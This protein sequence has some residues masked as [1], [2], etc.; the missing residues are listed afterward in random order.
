MTVS[1][2]HRSL[3]VTA[4]ILGLSLG[5]NLSAAERVAVVTKVKGTV[6]VRPA[7]SNPSFKQVKAGQVLSDRDFLR[8]GPSAFAVLIYLDDK[9]MVK[10]K[11][12]TNLEIQ[13]KRVGKGLEKNLEMTG[14]TVKAVVSKQR[15]GGF[16]ITSP[17]SVASVKG[18]SFWM[19][20]SLQTGDTV[21]NEEGVVQLTNLLSGSVL[22][23]LA[24]QTG[25]STPDGALSVA[26]TIAANVPVDEDEGDEE[27]Q[28]LRIRFTTPDGEEK[29]LI[30]KYH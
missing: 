8:T 12:N 11:G 9:S 2:H 26:A 20:S 15:R 27:V 30:I 14:G 7:T 23:L 16:T 17:T 10:L 18:T 6:E 28:E 19:V 1:P 21:F 29:V 13:G 3:I 4:L 25:T 24:D 5:T 22:D